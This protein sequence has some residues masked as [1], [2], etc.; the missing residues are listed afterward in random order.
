MSKIHPH[1][2]IIYSNTC[3]LKKHYNIYPKTLALFY[4]K[5]M[6]ICKCLCFFANKTRIPR[7]ELFQDS[8]FVVCFCHLKNSQEGMIHNPMAEDNPLDVT[9]VI[10]GIQMISVC[11][12][13]TKVCMLLMGLMYALNLEYHKKLKNTFEVFQNL[14]LDLDGDNKSFLTLDLT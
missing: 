4:K 13:K 7:E 14:L 2:L 6:L 5:L 10:E 12:Y 1:Y 11:V 8:Q 3:N 9:I